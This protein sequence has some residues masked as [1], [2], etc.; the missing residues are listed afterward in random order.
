MSGGEHWASV[1]PSV[2]STIECTIDCG[3]TTTSIAVSGRSKRRCAS[4]SSRPLFTSVAELMVTTG[5]IRQVGCAR[6]C[7]GVTDLE[8]SGAPTT[9]RPAAGSQD[10]PPHF[11]CAAATKALGQ[12]GMLGIDGHDL[13]RLRAGL[14]QRAADDQRLLVREREG[15][16]SAAARRASAPGRS[17]PSCRSARCRRW[18][19]RRP[20]A[21]WRS[22]Q[23]QS[24]PVSSFGVAVGDARP[25][26]TRWP[27]AAATSEVGPWATPTTSTLNSTAWSASRSSRSPPL[28]RPTT[29][30]RSG[31][32]RITS[33]A[34]VPIEP[35]DPRITTSLRWL[36]SPVSRTDPSRGSDPAPRR[37]TPP[38]RG[39][40]TSG[41]AVPAPTSSSRP[42]TA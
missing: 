26:L 2:N 36:T 6:A 20:L 22:G 29:R 24:G 31:L 10:Q 13:T 35:V 41:R 9:K 8:V 28:A 42:A 32:R 37:S 23:Q 39:R 21:N 34:W 17:S 12:R 16:A 38:P 25:A 30:N 7:A 3:C 15:I 11:G 4:I 19:N 14:D 27:I 1:E 40:S 18:A 33:S 5:P